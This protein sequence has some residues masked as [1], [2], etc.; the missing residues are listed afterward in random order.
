MSDYHSG[1]PIRTQADPDER[2]QCKLVDY[3]TPG[4][5]TTVD[6]DGNAH[7][8]VHGNRVDDG[9]DVA[10]RLSEEG[11]ANI[12]GDYEVDENSKPASV[13]DIAHTRDASIDETKQLQRVTAIPGENNSVC[14]DVAMHDA[15]GNEYDSNNPLPVSIEE[16]PG[17]EVQDYDTAVAIAKDADSVHSYS[18]ADGKT[19]LF[20]QILSSSSGKHRVMIEI[21]DGGVSEVFAEKYVDFGSTAK[22]GVDTT[23]AEPFKVIGTVNTTTIK[24]TRNNRDDAAMD[25]YSTIVG[26]LKDT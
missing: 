2:V 14:K 22:P 18:I 3:T 9:N 20:K 11:N 15:S 26:N 17:E 7:V 25:M 19:F 1:L 4:Q 8:E 16:S 13:A 5:G 24:I 12:R 10:L 6:T 21:G 23:F